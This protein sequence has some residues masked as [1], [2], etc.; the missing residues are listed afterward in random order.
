MLKNMHPDQLRSH[1]LILEHAGKVRALAGTTTMAF[2]L[3]MN[4]DML[5]VVPSGPASGMVSVN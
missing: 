5:V 2:K 1:I 3:A 4:D